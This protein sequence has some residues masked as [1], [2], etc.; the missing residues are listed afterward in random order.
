[1][2]IQAINNQNNVSHRAYIKNDANGNLK[3]LW[4]KTTKTDWFLDNIKKLTENCPQHEIEI[5]EVTESKLKS[6]SLD[7]L[8]HNNT[9]GKSYLQTLSENAW[10]RNASHFPAI[11]SKLIEKFEKNDDFCKMGLEAKMFDRLTRNDSLASLDK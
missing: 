10:D 5:L 6:N 7:Y 9:T 8:I 4:A 1:M 3:R 2:R 11:L